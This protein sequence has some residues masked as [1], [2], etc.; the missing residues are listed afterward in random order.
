MNTDL[1]IVRLRDQM[2]NAN[3]EALVLTHPHDVHY[4]T[5]YESILEHWTLQEPLSAA[6]V[7]L[8]ESM[9]VILCLP[10]TN[11]A[12]LAVQQERGDPDRADELRVFD[13]LS[14]CDMARKPDEF[15]K[16]TPL[17][18]TSMSI[19]ANRVKGDCSEH[20]I[21]SILQALTDH[22]LAQA[23]LGVDDLRVGQSIT[24]NDPACS[25]TDA[26]ELVVRA[27]IVKTPPELGIFREI[28]PIADKAVQAAAAALHPGVVW[29]EVQY[30]VADTMARMGARPVD[31]GAMLF[32]GAFD[33]TFVP[34]LFRTP[35]DKP[36]QE[37]Q[38]V[39]LEI[40]GICKG[41]WIDINRTAVIGQPTPAYSAMHD[42]IR[43]A[44]LT[45]AEQMKPGNSTG[46]LA[47]IGY[48][49]VKRHGVSA[50]EKLLIIAHGIGHMPLELPFPFPSLGLSG[51]KG[52]EIEEN[53]VISLD[54]LYF[55][56]E[57]GPCHMEN[58]FIIEADGAHSTYSTPLELLGP[59]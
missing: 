39:I 32:G 12:G 29:D 23:S 52:F 40:L 49:Y 28:G 51:S 5:G 16:S 45:M 43:D 48:E 9:P 25:I 4:A 20:L 18:D 24:S 37:G 56:S 14:F 19:Y 15:A 53:M 8:D 42:V 41:F 57:F 26:L 2:R 17:V 35:F 30:Q 1:R 33:N 13:L 21:S 11:I 47:A 7:A 31:H 36:L 38:I 10:E 6:I 58:V 46:D 34:E 44:F 50:P 55:G 22:G 27:R 59:R 3:L 54:C